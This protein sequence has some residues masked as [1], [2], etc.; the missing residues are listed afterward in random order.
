VSGSGDDRGPSTDW[1]LFLTTLG[2]IALV[3]LPIV[4]FHDQAAAAITAA[5][6]AITKQLGFLYL[7]YGIGALGFLGWIA[8]G[9]Y[10]SIRLGT[11]DSRPQFSTFSWVAMLFCA[12]V[13]ATLL[14]WAIVE[15]GYYID[16]PPHGLEPRSVAATE[17]AASYGM[18]HWGITGWAILCLP[19]IAIAYPYYVRRVPYLRLSTACSPFLP[20]GVNSP[21]GRALDFIYMINLIG[22]SGTSLGLSTPMIA[23]AVAEL[24]GLGHDFMLE[25]AVMVACIAVF[26]FSAWLGLERGFKRMSDA[27]VVLALALL[28]FVLIVGPTLFILKMGTNSI[29]LILQNFIRMNTWTDPVANAGFVESWTIFYW[30]WWMAYGPF[31]GIFIARISGGRT[32]RQVILGMLSFGSLGAAVFYIVLGNYAMH[33]DLGGLLDVSG[34]IARGQ[35]ARAITEVIASLPLEQLALAIF[36]LV[37]VVLLATT[38]DSAAYTLASVS[39]RRLE[40]GRNPARWSRL[41]WACALGFTPVTLLF[42][43]GGLKVVLS[44]TIVVSLP[45]LA[46]GVLMAASLVRQLRED[47][48]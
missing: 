16:K 36:V 23:A 1:V 10:G 14:Y 12:G 17:W 5:Y 26:G 22:G 39:T 4:A 18:F 28:L 27:T 24:L 9:R 8:F 15:W 42:V 48:R 37:S 33:L 20:G 21:R 13:G 38:Y 7:W 6:D 47:A 45:L 46:V 2:T 31:V 29:G 30:A 3:C 34:M 35:E 41:F 11:P 43:E 44:A 25:V 40:A 32:L 19:A